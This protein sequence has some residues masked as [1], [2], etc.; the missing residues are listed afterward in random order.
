MRRKTVLTKSAINQLVKAKDT[1]GII[2]LYEIDKE[3]NPFTEYSLQENFRNLRH[4]Q[5]ET[6]K[7]LIKNNKTFGLSKE[8][9]FKLKELCGFGKII[10][11]NNGQRSFIEYRPN[12]TDLEYP[13]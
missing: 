3:L 1:E 10:T 8:L 2:K 4:C 5:K 13:F 12:N 11:N 9:F 6:L 7:E